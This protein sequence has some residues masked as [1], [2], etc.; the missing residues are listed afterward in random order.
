MESRRI[1][2]IGASGFVG[3]TV[4][5]RLLAGG[6]DEVI[7]FIHSS[8]NAW[9]LAR[10]GIPLT[11]LDLLERDRVIAAMRGITHVV[12][13]SRG[14]DDLMIG[15]LGNLLVAGRAAGVKRFVHL[16]SVAVYGD[17]PP[18]E[19]ISEA[20]P[21]IPAKGSYGA[22]KLRQDRMV[23][24]AHSEGLPSLILCPPNISGVHS[25]YLLGIIAA[26]RD[27]TFALLD[28]GSTP[29]N[30][31]D[32]RNL[33]HAVE[34]AL[35]HNSPDGTRY[36][37]TDDEETSWGQVVD[38]LAPLAELTRPVANIQRD[39]LGGPDG[40]S[41]Q[42]AKINLIASL[43]HLVSS[44]V[45]EALRADPLW[46]RVDVALRRAVAHLGTRAESAL[47]LAVEGP[48]R[49]SRSGPDHPYATPLCRQQLRGVR[50]SCA[51]AKAMLGY[52]PQYTFA[53]SMRAFSAWYRDANGMAT[54]WWPLLRLL[55]GR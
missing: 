30:L 49:A 11:M 1:A 19:S 55:D 14:G 15:G 8:G 17:P 54:P 10:L 34:L 26:L 48:V 4:V 6:T 20:A 31:V 7:P 9:R 29:C 41:G 21:T 46:R 3:A 18:P 16:G 38:A 51:R 5:E 12:N 33:A 36:F 43:K 2:V 13:C 53:D 44:E 23:A 27:G 22:V 32:V 42:K 35:D 40:D 50:H 37:V 24:K 45:R 52:V 28:D 39:M 47:R 25:V